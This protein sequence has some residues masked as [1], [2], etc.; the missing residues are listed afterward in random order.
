VGGDFRPSLCG[1][2]KRPLEFFFRPISPGMRA[3][4]APL[5][6]KVFLEGSGFRPPFILANPSASSLATCH[7]PPAARAGHVRNFPRAAASGWWSSRVLPYINM[8]RGPAGGA[9]TR[10]LF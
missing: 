10:L 7:L 2:Q 1:G 4:Q 5:R 3:C 9:D 8:F 6:T